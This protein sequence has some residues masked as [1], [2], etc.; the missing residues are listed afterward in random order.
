MTVCTLI[1]LWV[2]NELSYDRFHQNADRIYR[3]T[4][5]ARIGTPQSA[6]VAPTPAGPA[7]ARDY[8]EILKAARLDRPRRSVIS[9]RG[10]GI[11]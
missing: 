1:M 3:L 5:D 4:L 10:Q 8:P 11:L 9:L 7:M 6:P 2:Q